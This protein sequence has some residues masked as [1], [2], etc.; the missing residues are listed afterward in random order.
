[1]SNLAKQHTCLNQPPESVK[2]SGVE[3]YALQDLQIIHMG[4]AGSTSC[5]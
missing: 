1:M 3:R 5:C 2:S 4:A